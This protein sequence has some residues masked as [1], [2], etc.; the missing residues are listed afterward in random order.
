MFLPVLLL[1]ALTGIA[2][3]QARFDVPT[4]NPAVKNPVPFPQIE[5]IARKLSIE[6][7]G[8]GALGVPIPLT[9][10][11]GNL[12]AYMFPFHIGAVV[13]PSHEEISAR[14][15]E[16]RDLQDHIDKH[17]VE[18]AREK[19]LVLKQKSRRAPAPALHETVRAVSDAPVARIDSLRPDGSR[20]RRFEVAEI[21][22]ME[23]FARRRASGEDDFGTIV[24]SATYDRVPVPVYYHHLPTY[25]TRQDL[26]RE[27]AEQA[28]G[29]G[30]SLQRIHFLGLRGQVFEFANQRG[31]VLIHGATLEV[32]DGEIAGL[33]SR[34]LQPSPPP[35]TDTDK[36]NA[37]VREKLGKE[38]DA[39]LAEIG[40][41]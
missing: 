4:A 30:A 26:A 37:A 20:P 24:V 14:V 6:K 12:T 7:W 9:D 40:E 33:R 23:S 15:K 18:E 41:K 17:R 21:R 34:R 8:N 31:K 13:F 35:G 1:S 5:K 3:S 38:W 28:I 11:D 19:Y 36:R 29:P 39:V 10:L 16:G 2:F 32:K 25:F 22:E 27:R